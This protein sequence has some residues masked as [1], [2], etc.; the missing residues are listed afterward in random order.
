MLRIPI[1]LISN[2]FKHVRIA[3]ISSRPPHSHCPSLLYSLQVPYKLCTTENWFPIEQHPPL[4]L[5]SISF[6]IVEWKS[7][8]WNLNETPTV[9]I[10]KEE[11]S[12]ARTMYCVY[13]SVHPFRWVLIRLTNCNMFPSEMSRY[14]NLSRAWYRRTCISTTTT[15]PSY[16]PDKVNFFSISSL[17][18]CVQ[19]T[20]N[21]EYAR[22]RCKTVAAN[23]DI[24]MNIHLNIRWNILHIHPHN[25]KFTQ[26]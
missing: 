14:G 20:T 18:R 19:T 15:Y 16:L 5:V 9:T 21:I 7:K 23:T 11:D 3:N 24:Q 8:S 12:D 6:S 10:K 4:W 26:T 2:S 25:H 1:L 17:N 22:K 13:S